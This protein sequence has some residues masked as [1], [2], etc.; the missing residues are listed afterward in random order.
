MLES[1]YGWANE[2]WA[3]NLAVLVVLVLCWFMGVLF[4]LALSVSF[5]IFAVLSALLLARK[6][7]VESMFN[8]Y[9]READLV[10]AK[11]PASDPVSR[12][13]ERNY[14]A[15]SRGDSSSYDPLAP[16]PF[17]PDRLEL[18]DE[19]AFLGEFCCEKSPKAVTLAVE[20]T[21][22]HVTGGEDTQVGDYVVIRVESC[23]YTADEFCHTKLCYSL[24]PLIEA[25]L[26]SYLV[27]RNVELEYPVYV[28]SKE[29]SCAIGELCK[30]KPVQ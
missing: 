27:E 13:W 1:I 16:D 12:I 28:C 3:V 8:R 11:R 6:C 2:I 21:P 17:G 15:L 20:E 18:D 9:R 24:K 5:G 14:I 25:K 10:E 19:L 7:Y 26:A 22:L 30:Y 23:G 29:P 4:P